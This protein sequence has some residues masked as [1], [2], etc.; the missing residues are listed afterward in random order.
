MFDGELMQLDV[1]TPGWLQ[2]DRRAEASR[3][4][5]EAGLELLD[6]FGSVT[7]GCGS[8]EACQNARALVKEAFGSEAGATV[9]RARPKL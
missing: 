5:R 7:V 3:L 1:T 2:H 8:Y 4:M 6:L 9:R